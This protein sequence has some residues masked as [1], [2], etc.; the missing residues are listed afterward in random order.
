VFQLYVSWIRA[1]CPEPYGKCAEYTALMVAEFPELRR[2]RGHYYCPAWGE[3]EHW[4]CV[5]LGGTIVDPTAAQ[6]PSNGTGEYVEWDES[7]PEPTG[8][9]PNCGG[10]VFGGYLCS[11]RCD[12]EYRR[13]VSSPLT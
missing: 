1:N 13:Y 5:A 8:K 6:F 7:K 3:R 9:C 11:D 4:W 2:V 10:Y 12:E